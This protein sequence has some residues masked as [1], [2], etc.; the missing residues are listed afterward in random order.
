MGCAPAVSVLKG[1]LHHMSWTC[2]F[3]LALRISQPGNLCGVNLFCPF[4]ISLH[5]PSLERSPHDVN[6]CDADGEL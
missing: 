2:D 3:N 1:Q 4:Y 6:H 5:I